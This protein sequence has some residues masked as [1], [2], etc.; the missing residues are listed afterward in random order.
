M[1][2]KKN[3][4]YM[5]APTRKFVKCIPAKINSGYK[6]GGKG[7]KLFTGF[8][9]KCKPIYGATTLLCRE[10]A[11]ESE[12]LLTK[13]LIDNGK[14]NEDSIEN[15]VFKR[16]YALICVRASMKVIKN[17]MRQL[18]KNGNA[19]IIT[20]FERRPFYYSNVAVNNVLYVNNF[21]ITDKQMHKRFTSLFCKYGEL[22]KDIKMGTDRNYDPYAIVHFRHSDDAMQC[23]QDQNIRF[24]GKKLSINYSKKM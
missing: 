3:I 1:N 6:Y 17:K 18:N 15:I 14:F 2:Q 22:V 12:E 19:Q 13:Y 21:D 23:V 8:K 7:F 5:P 11:N 24:G 9:N 16:H 20:I 4:E 10:T